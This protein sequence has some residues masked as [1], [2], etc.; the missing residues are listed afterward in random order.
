MYSHVLG[1]AEPTVIYQ[2]GPGLIEARK[3]VTA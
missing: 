2:L 1:N 3:T